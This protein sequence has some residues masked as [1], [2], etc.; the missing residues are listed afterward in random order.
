MNRS[1]VLDNLPVGPSDFVVEIG[2]GPMPFRHTKL[3]VDKYPFDNSERHGDIANVAPVIKADA[4]RLPLADGACDVLF[5]SHVLE[6]IDE[7]RR[8]LE[9]A[10]RCAKRIYLEFPT[11]LR[12]MMYAWPFHRWLIEFRENQLVFYKNDVP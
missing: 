7:P 4:A 6:H 8:F 3:I 9:E 2:A 5:V 1:T 10:R 12:E 11:A